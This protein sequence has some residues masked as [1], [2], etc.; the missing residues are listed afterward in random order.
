M[1]DS[2]GASGLD[3]QRRRSARVMFEADRGEVEGE[4]DDS[5]AGQD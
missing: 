1:L 5:G 3:R 4:G 2:E